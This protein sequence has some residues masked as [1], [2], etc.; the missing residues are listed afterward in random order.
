MGDRM[1]RRAFVAGTAIVGGMTAGVLPEMAQ[2][3]SSPQLVGS[4]SD[5]G[6]DVGS[7][8]N[9]LGLRQFGATGEN[10]YADDVSMSAGSNVVSSPT[11]AAALSSGMVAVIASAGLYG[12]PAALHTAVTG[13]V[14]SLISVSGS[15]QNVVGDRNITNAG[16]AAVIA[17]SSAANVARHGTLSGT[18]AVSNGATIPHGLGT[19]AVSY[20]AT[21]SVAGRLVAVTAAHRPGM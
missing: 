14:G 1:S 17:G 7:R 3:G 12:N 13:F 10:W 15:L 4:G 5:S 20:S 9:P 18:A 6:P 16:S 8:T 21:P 19:I 11:L 2:A